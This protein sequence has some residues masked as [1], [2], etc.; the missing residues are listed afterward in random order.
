MKKLLKNKYNLIAIGTIAIIILSTF[1]FFSFKGVITKKEWD[2]LQLG[3]SIQEVEKQI[4]KPR[5]IENNPATI[6]ENI[7]SAYKPL[8]EMNNIVSDDNLETRLD[9]LNELSIAVDS[10]KNIKEYTYLE[11]SSSG[12][13]EVQ[14][15]FVNG[16]AKYF[17][18]E[19][20]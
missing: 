8:Y 4:G 10:K 18:R 11:K 17:N 1:I 14:V 12:K 16:A 7:Y 5:K 6:S 20:Q 2:S 13:R 9:A 19:K 15:Y 3:M